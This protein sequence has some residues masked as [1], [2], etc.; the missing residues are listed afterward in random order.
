MAYKWKPSAAQKKV[1][2]ERM[3]DK[4]KLTVQTTP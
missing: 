2:A 3:Q 1:Y 4:E